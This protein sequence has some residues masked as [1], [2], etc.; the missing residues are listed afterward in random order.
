[1]GKI[2]KIIG[3]FVHA[4]DRFDELAGRIA[5]TNLQIDRLTGQRQREWFDRLCE[6]REMLSRLNRGLSISYTVWGDPSRLEIDETAKV[7]TC[8]FNTNSGRIR[9]G[10]ATFAGSDV[11]VLAGAHDPKLTGYLRRDADMTEAAIS[12]SAKAYGWRAGARCWG[13]AGSGTTR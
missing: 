3:S 1:M 2:K 10:E 12:R 11:S 8:F 5:E 6:D 7:F 13:R 4:P 9:I